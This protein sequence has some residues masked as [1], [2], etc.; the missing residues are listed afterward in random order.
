MSKVKAKSDNPFQERFVKLALRRLPHH[1]LLSVSAR[2]SNGRL[3]ALLNDYARRTFLKNPTFTKGYSKKQLDEYR[4]LTRSATLWHGTGRYHHSDAGIQDVLQSILDQGGLKPAYDAYAIFSSG[5]EMYSIS[6]TPYRI[7]ARS[8]S[9]IHGKGYQEPNRYGDALMWVS[10]FYGLFYAKMYTRNAITTKR[11]YK[12]WHSLAHDTNGDNTW[13]KK[14]NKNA[15]DVWD[16]FGLGS[17]IP[18]NYPILIGVRQVE[19]R[20]NLSPV[21]EA[22]EVRT[23]AGIMIA[24][25][26][27][28]EVPEEKVGMT[29]EI[30]ASHGL[31]KEVVPIELGEYDASYKAFGQLIGLEKTVDVD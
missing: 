7:I 10:Y 24:N 25:I 29:K 9:D 5:Q 17:D 30:L 23:A 28:I 1:I 6:L 3:V 8:Y 26:T 2:R 19:E 31:E 14:V 16:V 21:F 20:V 13:G 4:A 22:Y 15:R 11:Y 27:H 12:K 18:G